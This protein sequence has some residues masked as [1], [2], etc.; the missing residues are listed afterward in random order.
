M[1]LGCWQ[2][3]TQGEASSG[4]LAQDFMDLDQN[5]I[6]SSYLRSL[7]SILLLSQ[8]LRSMNSLSCSWCRGGHVDLSPKRR[9][10]SFGLILYVSPS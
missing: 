1:G 8:E 5:A 9:F 7:H 3:A 10:H 6:L 4:L 2:G